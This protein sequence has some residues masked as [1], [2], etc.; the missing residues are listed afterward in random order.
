MKQQV[1]IRPLTTLRFFAALYVVLYHTLPEP[2]RAF[3][4]HSVFFGYTSVSFFF[5]LSGFVLAIAYAKRF[6]TLDKKEFWRARFAR[7]YPLFL[8]TA[9]IDTPNLLFTRVAKYGVAS[10]VMKTSVT[11][12]ATIL[13][14]QAWWPQRLE[15][16]DNPNWSLSVETVFYI[17]FPFVVPMLWRKSTPAAVSILLSIYLGGLAL[18]SLAMKLHLPEETI[19]YLPAL[20]VA[21]FVEGA[22]L[23]RLFVGWTTNERTLRNIQLSTFPV[24]LGSIASF[25]LLV[26]QPALIPKPFLHDGGL[27]LIFGSIIVVFASG[28]SIVEAVF[29]RPFFVLLGEASYAL[30]LI[31]IVLWHYVERFVSGPH[32]DWLYSS[33]L[34]AAIALSVVSLRFFEQ[35]TRRWILKGTLSRNMETPMTS[36]IS[37]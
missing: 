18:I 16:I 2:Y 19:I 4:H 26:F 13:M 22:L 34:V 1:H 14:L 7:I 8:L 23:S 11:F 3:G 20:H 24:I 5:I 25:L 33:Y 32:I 31:H 12:V 9:C 17:L 36:S 35:P 6:S 27:F 30:Y 15:G 28:H 29:G 10:A 37:Q 21:E